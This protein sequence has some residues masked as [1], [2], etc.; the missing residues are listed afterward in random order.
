[1]MIEYFLYEHLL[2]NLL[3]L[4]VLHYLRMLS[5]LFIRTADKM[6]NHVLYQN[7]TLTKVKYGYTGCQ[8]AESIP[9]PQ[10]LARLR[11]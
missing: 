7:K 6:K 9:R 8:G 1:M 11:E 4:F 10:Q 3:C 5:S 2:Y